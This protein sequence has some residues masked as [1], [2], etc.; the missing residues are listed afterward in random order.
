MSSTCHRAH[1]HDHSSEKFV[2]TTVFAGGA[3]AARTQSANGSLKGQ[4]EPPVEGERTLMQ[5]SV[6]RRAP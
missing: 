2:T 5:M 6:P 3:A 1:D 4:S